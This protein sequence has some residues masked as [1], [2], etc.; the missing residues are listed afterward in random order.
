MLVS[1][2]LDLVPI[3]LLLVDLYEYMEADVRLEY[4]TGD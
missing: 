3:W 1:H 4:Y 2:F